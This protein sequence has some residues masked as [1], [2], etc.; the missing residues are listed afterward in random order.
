MNGR[1]AEKKTESRAGWLAGA[2]FGP[3][4]MEILLW[5]APAGLQ[6]HP[7]TPQSEKKTSE[8]ERR[9]KKTPKKKDAEIKDDRLFH[10]GPSFFL[11]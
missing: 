3:I 1:Q 10:F 6:R 9:R 4:L 7:K 8:K 11:M 5:R 2:R